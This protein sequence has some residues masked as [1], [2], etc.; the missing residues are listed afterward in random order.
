MSMSDPI[1]DMLTR[2]RNASARK[3][4][5]VVMP[6]STVK[7]SIANVMVKE[8]FIRSV[9]MDDSSVKKSLTLVLKYHGTQS[10]PACAAISRISRPGLRCYKKWDMIPRNGFGIVIVS[11]SKGMMSD[12]DARALHLGGELICKLSTVKTE[13]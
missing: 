4:K 8:G 10:E 11:T 13:A 5:I 6:Y 12:H 3:A 9:S 7:H 2:V 1:A